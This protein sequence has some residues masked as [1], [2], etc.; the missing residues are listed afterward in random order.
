[1]RPNFGDAG[2]A[3]GTKRRWGTTR[4]V[5]RTVRGCEARCGRCDVA[6]GHR[7]RHDHP[8]RGTVARDLGRSAREAFFMFWETLWALVLGFGLSGIVQSFVSK[9]ELRTRIGAR[10]PAE[11]ARA[12]GYGMVSSSCSYAASA[13]AKTL[14]A[15]GADF[16][17]AMVFMIAS[18]NLVVEL[19]IVLLVLIGW[20]FLVAQYVGG[21]IMITL[22]ALVGGFPPRPGGR[23][24]ESQIEPRSRRT[25]RRADPAR[26]RRDDGRH[27][28]HRSRPLASPLAARMDRRL[29]LCGR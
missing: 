9:D 13:M 4:A 24:R 11:V 17:A 1:M 14:F 20:Q 28:G 19:G 25:H 23:R 7:G 29:E 18:T 8:R 26:R 27:S 12:S 10:G 16:V 6:I 2:T 5:P 22:F 3:T 15:R 21:V